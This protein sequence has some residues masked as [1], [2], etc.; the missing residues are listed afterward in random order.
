MVETGQAAYTMA[1]LIFLAIFFLPSLALGFDLSLDYSHHRDWHVDNGTII[2]NVITIRAANE[3][4]EELDY[5]GYKSYGEADGIVTKDNAGAGIGYDPALND[6]WSLWF[7]GAWSYDN[8]LGIDSEILLGGGPKYYAYKKDAQ[9]LSISAGIL[10]H[11]REPGDYIEQRWSFRVKGSTENW[12][13]VGFYQPNVADSS[14]YI[15]KGE[16]EGQVGG[17]VY[18]FWNT[19][20]RSIDES[21]VTAMGLRFKYSTGG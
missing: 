10:H 9:R 15:S 12:K 16:V 4:I 8:A 20:Y 6:Q 19:A 11:S 2:S 17:S 14:D 1:R 7:D 13:A 3:P 21:Q 5:Y 18:V